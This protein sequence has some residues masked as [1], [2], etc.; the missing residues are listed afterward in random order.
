MY[1]KN[2]RFY[3]R[4]AFGV[5]VF[6][7][8]YL[9]FLL[10][11]L[12]S[13]NTFAQYPQLSS[14]EIKSPAVTYK[15]GVR[16][17][18]IITYI[19][20]DELARK[21]NFRVEY[22]TY[23][24]FSDVIHSLENNMVDFSAN[25]TYSKD[26]DKLLDIS[27]PTNIEYIYFYSMNDPKRN[28]S[29]K[30][31]H[32]IGVTKDSI[33]G[34]AIKERYSTVKVIEF[35]NIEQAKK[36]ILNH[37]IDGV[38]DSIVRLP[39]FTNDGFKVKMLNDIVPIPPVGLAT[40][41]GRNTQ[42]MKDMVAYIHTA[43]MQRI[44][45]RS[46]ESYKFNIQQKALR[47]I[48]LAS[49][50][51]PDI[52]LKVKLENVIQ[53]SEYGPN[54]E[55][56]GISTD[57]LHKAC[58]ILGLKCQVV[59]KADDSWS[60]MY[61]D[62]VHNKI[63]ILG[64]ITISFSRRKVINFSHAYF[65]P[66]AIMAKRAGYKEATY[67]NVSE[68]IIERISVLKGDYYDDLLTS[69]LPGQELVKLNSR[70][71]QIKSLLAG[72]TDYAVL[73]EQSYN[74][75]LQENDTFLPIVKDTLIGDFHHSEL[76]FGFTKT[77]QGEKLADLFTRAIDLI[78]TTPIVNKYDIKPD[79]R[80]TLQREKRSNQ[81]LICGFILNTLFMASVIW[82]VYRQSIIDNLTKLKNRRALYQK[83]S[84]G[85]PATKTVVY[86]DIN[87]FKII[88]DTYG[89]QMGDEVLK[90]LAKQISTYW[91]D[92]SFRLGGDEFVLI[93]SVKGEKLE[94]LLN[95]IRTFYFIADGHNL[96]VNTS[97]GISLDREKVMKVDD[98]LN[99]AD[100]EMYKK[101]KHR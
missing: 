76:S 86:L 16:P 29:I 75:M 90:L 92:Q 47:A 42:L 63:D 77:E 37:E 57:I 32:R 89:H 60:S 70:D 62:L 30:N 49:G 68:M 59:S 1:K 53:F 41:N 88:N 73:N 82:Y 50:I 95:P 55:T 56:F 98:V 52:P 2:S 100:I 14:V 13:T 11:G 48:V 74:K 24:T 15:V 79:W 69:M 39:T 19:L 9:F 78:D 99:A 34:D 7:Y 36:M 27:S 101:K 25:I 85:V 5:N 67:K 10:F 51:N 96:M 38:V 40:Q 54:G 87:N 97:M 12:Y 31:I 72:N 8:G 6:R 58:S 84:R 83:Y 80:G 28:I 81:M 91:P 33:L 3:S 64:P 44:L 94:T 18:D 45:R 46:I 35:D 66:E 23:N 22:I 61:S 93:G 4:L 43:R 71:E 65:Y 17:N 26:R 20:F 21:F